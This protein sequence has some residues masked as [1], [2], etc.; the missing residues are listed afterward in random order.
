MAIDICL[1]KTSGPV[2]LEI[3]A[4]A[5]LGVQIA[6]LAPLRRR[7]ER[8]EGIRVTNP[9][10]G[11]RIAKDMFGNTVEKEIETLSGK[12]VIGT[13]ENIE[14]IQKSGIHHLS[15]KIDTTRT[16]SII[17]Q[18]TA[19]KIGLLNKEEEYDD[20]KST[21]KIKFS[22]KGHRIQTIVDI[23][24]IDS[25]KHKLI[26][27]TRDLSN[28]LIETTIKQEEKTKIPTVKKITK[29][30]PHT[31]TPNFKKMDKDLIEVDSKIKLLYHLKPTNL[32]SE[33]KKFL[34]NPNKDPQFEYPQLKF[35]PVELTHAL[36]KIKPDNSP[37]GKIFQAKKKE[38]F[39]KISLI[40]AIDE[41][42]FSEISIKL[43]GKPGKDDLLNAK[44]LITEIDIENI[45]KQESIFTEED[46]IKRFN[47]IFAKYGLKNWKAKIKDSMVAD[48]IAG[49]NNRLFIRKGARFNKER[50][51]S[52]IVHEIETHILTA[53]NGKMQ[54]YEIFNRGLA[55]YLQTQEGMAMWNVEQQRK[56]P[57]SQNYSALAHVIAID[58][59]LKHSFSKTYATLIELGIPATTAFKSCLKA[60]RGI[61]DTS[62]P[63]AFTKD[64]VYYKGYYQ[65][66]EF[67]EKGGQLRD[68]YI[69]KMDV[70]D[71]DRAK[72][73]SG[74]R[75]AMILPG[76]LK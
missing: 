1:D 2:L 50:I 68:L 52:L 17:D 3:N 24:D 20:E 22:L 59:A 60:K 62:K 64:L 70:A 58:S 40:E 30:L 57:F 37:L 10:K 35:D 46:A 56:H 42:R 31:K 45:K 18:E 27:G 69:G 41:E 12:P 73:I 36:E 14:L 23:E 71:V 47:E 72:E 13:E 54:P 9:T 67:I 74:V 4:R 19:K 26:I 75:D 25:E 21:L 51:E 76:W 66:R 6:N 48:C 63:G 39:N 53:E 11:V 7:L 29:H 43:F 32:E 33:K 61:S 55:N 49:K 38:I 15:A 16:R 28:F 65:V 44:K 8:I 34:D 5:G